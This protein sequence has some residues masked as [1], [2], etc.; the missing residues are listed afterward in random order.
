LHN[1]VLLINNDI[2]ERSPLIEPF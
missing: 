1:S 2:E